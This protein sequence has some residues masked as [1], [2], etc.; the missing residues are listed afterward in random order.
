MTSINIGEL[1]HSTLAEI[2]MNYMS[3]IRGGA[4]IGVPPDLLR[5]V[6]QLEA[7]EVL[8]VT[9]DVFN[10]VDSMSSNNL[11]E[12]F[13]FAQVVPVNSPTNRVPTTRPQL[14]I[15]RFPF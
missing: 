2:N 10:E 9:E 11:S 8:V 15:R 7:I 13:N 3:L 14:P 6:P 1:S 4:T 12:L 5:Y